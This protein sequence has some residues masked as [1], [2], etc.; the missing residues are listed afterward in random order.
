MKPK[1]EKDLYSILCVEPNATQEE[2]REAYLSRVRVIHPDRFDKHSQAKEWQIANEMLAE[3]NDAYSI[4]KN[5]N[6]RDEYDYLRSKNHCE[7]SSQTK[8]DSYQSQSPPSNQEFSSGQAVFKSL[9]EDVQSRLLKRQR[10]DKMNQLQIKLDGIAWNYIFTLILLCWYWYL[11]SQADSAKWKNETIAWYA[12][13]TLFVGLLIGRNFNTI[14]RWSKATLKSYFYV[15]P[16]YFIKTEFDTISF[17]PIWSLK[18]VSI[19]HNYKNNSYENTDVVLKF[20]GY[21]ENLTLPT[22]KLVDLMFEK[23]KT[24]DTQMRDAYAK[25]NYQYFHENNDFAQAPHS[26]DETY[27]SWPK[28]KRIIAY[29]FF[30]ILCTVGL[31]ATINVNDELSEKQWVRHPTPTPFSPKPMPLRTAKPSYPEQSL[32]YNG[33][34][35]KYISTECIAPFEIKAAL[36]SH[37]LVKLVNAYTKTSVLTVFVRS[38][39]TVCIDVPLGVYEV[40]Y[41]SGNTWYGYEYL[42]G[43]ETSYSKADKTFSFEIDGDQVNGFTITLYQVPYGNL[44]TSTIKPTDF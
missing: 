39:S 1:R 3:L 7:T 36:G 8:Q 21:N 29:F 9:S 31:C 2:I 42:F 12:G 25:G 5:S 23:I 22:K 44:N 20:D 18:D 33:S 14:M 26:T 13:V 34:I 37:Y 11:Y 19:T 40:R 24:Y 38:G 28:Y 41:A 35:Q 4:L 15:T 32:P 17:R 43:P 27:E 30:V 10:N 6:T 16:L